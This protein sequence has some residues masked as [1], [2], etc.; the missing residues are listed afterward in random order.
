[1]PPARL[2]IPV[3]I[4]GGSGST[5]VDNTGFSYEIGD[6]SIAGAPPFAPVWFQWTAPQDGEVE[7]DTIGST[8]LYTN[9]NYDFSVFPYQIITNV[10]LVNLDTVLGVIAARV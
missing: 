3:V 4:S 1:M 6:P 5:S 9:F 10:S 8:A 2:P 7:L